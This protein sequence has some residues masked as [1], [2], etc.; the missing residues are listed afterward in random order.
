MTMK[1]IILAVD[2][3]SSGGAIAIAA[4]L[5]RRLGAHVTIVHFGSS[6]TFGE[7]A[8]A[9]V[10]ESLERSG[11][12]FD[13]RIEQPNMGATT[14][15]SLVNMADAVHA[16]LI[17]LGSRG[18]PAPLTSLFGSVSREVAQGAHVPVL[19]VREA[20]HR[21]GTPAHLLLVVTEETLGSRELDAGIEL[22][23]GL[24]ARV[25]ILHVHGLLEDA[26]EDLLR[27]P[28]ASRPDHIANLLLARFG[29]AGIE[30][31]LVIADNHDGL[32]SEITRAAHDAGCD[33]IVI[34][35]G[36]SDVAER[37]VLGTVDEEVGRRSGRPVLVA[38]P[39]DS[40]RTGSGER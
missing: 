33:L 28:A 22:A 21:M 37:W 19:I 32:A 9:E 17:V 24:G 4:E 40:A 36:T 7:D 11:V 12:A 34:P 18:R 15:D 10:V 29:A 5:A 8:V 16:D 3:D 14:A 6:A 25:T 38:P 35:A 13:I 23:R 31:S 39:T 30:A 2:T 27:V 26:V 20:A 1:S